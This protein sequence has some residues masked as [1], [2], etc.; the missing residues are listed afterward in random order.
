[1]RTYGGVHPFAAW[2]TC[3]VQVRGAVGLGGT[4]SDIYIHIYILYI[5]IESFVFN[6]IQPL[7]TESWGSIAT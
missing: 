1:M 7:V 3:A 6:F 2:T 4:S 5:L